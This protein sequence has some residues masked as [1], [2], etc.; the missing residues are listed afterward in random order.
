[1][2]FGTASVAHVLRRSIL[3]HLLVTP[4]TTYQFRLVRALAAKTGVQER[5]H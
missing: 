3:W 5:L 4:K 2:K 1:M